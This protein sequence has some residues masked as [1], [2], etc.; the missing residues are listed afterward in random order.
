[1]DL[2]VDW[3]AFPWF[4][5]FSSFSGSYCRHVMKCLLLSL[6]KKGIAATAACRLLISKLKTIFFDFSPGR[7][8]LRPKKEV[9]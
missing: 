5:P 2:V 9:I 4:S 7:E 1:M 3:P 6:S 8:Q